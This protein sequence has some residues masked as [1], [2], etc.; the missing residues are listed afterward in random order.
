MEKVASSTQCERDCLLGGHRRAFRPCQF[1]GHIPEP[2][3][4]SGQHSHDMHL[5]DL[6]EWR[7]NANPQSFGCPGYLS[8]PLEN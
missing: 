4:Y 3:V 5:S 7:A 8:Y 1:K 6:F 2:S